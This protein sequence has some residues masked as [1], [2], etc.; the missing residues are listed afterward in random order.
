MV[1]S[2]TPLRRYSTSGCQFG[3]ARAKLGAAVSSKA[4]SLLVA[5]CWLLVMVMLAS[6]SSRAL[7]RSRES[8]ANLTATLFM[9]SDIFFMTRFES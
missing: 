4:G 2:A 1:F 3:I 5:G 6:S 8:Y 9:K 7:M